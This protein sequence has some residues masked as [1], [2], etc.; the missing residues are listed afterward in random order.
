MVDSVFECTHLVTDKV[1]SYSVY[2]IMTCFQ[3]LFLNQC[4]VTLPCSIVVSR[5]KHLYSSIS[6]S[7]FPHSPFS[8]SPFPVSSFPIPHSLIPHFSIP[9]SLIPQV[10]RTV[11]F[12]CCLARGC[13]IVNDQWLDHCREE[14]RFLPP[15]AYL[16]KDR[17]A[18]RQH[19]FSLSKLV[20]FPILHVLYWET[21]P[22]SCTVLV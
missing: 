16:V 2:L 5:Q 8:I 14:G 1:L 13:H 11:K 3:N 10:R 12:L 9:R 6:H 21:V 19:K 22:M 15:E 20:A 17:T 7:P 4:C 18:E